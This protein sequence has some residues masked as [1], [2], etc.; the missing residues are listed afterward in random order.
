MTHWTLPSIFGLVFLAQLTF[1]WIFWFTYGDA[2][3]TCWVC[4]FIPF[5]HCR[6][7]ESLSISKNIFDPLPTNVEIVQERMVF[8]ILFIVNSTQLLSF[9]NIHHLF[10][11]KSVD[12]HI[13]FSGYITTISLTAHCT[14]CGTLVGFH[15]IHF[16]GKKLHQGPFCKSKGHNNY[17]PASTLHRG[18]TLVIASHRM[19]LI[20]LM[21]YSL[22]TDAM[23]PHMHFWGTIFQ[24]L[25]TFGIDIRDG[26][27]RVPKISNSVS[28]RCLFHHHVSNQSE[29]TCHFL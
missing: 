23:C 18:G 15:H 3:S 6:C 16:P 1:P 29:D 9:C 20:I 17:F 22:C 13:T 5:C 21:S 12:I 25:G 2:I 10:I 8:E 7:H 4:L 27:C 24:S 11:H 26:F 14:E 28:G 19:P